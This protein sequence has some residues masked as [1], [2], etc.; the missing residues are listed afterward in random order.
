MMKKRSLIRELL[1]PAN[2]LSLSRIPILIAM[3]MVYPDQVVFL[4]LLTVAIMTDALDGYV[5]RKIGPTKLGAFLDPATDKLFV[6]GLLIF[7]VFASGLS[8]VHLTLLMLRDVYMV[9]VV[10]VFAFHESSQVLKHKIKAR[11]PGKL[12]T[13]G[14]F[15]A[16][17]WLVL[18]LP[19]FGY[20][21]YLVAAVSLIAIIDYSIFIEKQIKH[22][23]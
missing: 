6:G 11:W 12:T 5:A 3:I 22:H 20:L 8:I 21:I 10:A 7:L 9:I 2:I 14:Q 1:N 16:L 4:I 18:E 15:V 17:L 13:V 23:S 19:L